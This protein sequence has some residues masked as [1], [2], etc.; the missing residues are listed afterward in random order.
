MGFHDFQSKNEI[1]ETTKLLE[2]VDRLLTHLNMS[3]ITPLNQDSS[4]R[5]YYEIIISLLETLYLEISSQL[6]SKE[7]EQNNTQRDKIKNTLK[8]KPIF[9]YRTDSSMSGRKQKTIK[10]YDNWNV[11]KEVLF[12]YDRMVRK[13]INLHLK[14]QIYI[15]EGDIVDGD[16]PIPIGD[17]EDNDD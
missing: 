9:I 12:D 11:L 3:W 13:W 6:D 4:G 7:E 8:D 15:D 5:Y 10:D 17:I 16:E 14:K 1:S 2:R